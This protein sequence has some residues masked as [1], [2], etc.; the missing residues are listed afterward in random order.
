[1]K[2]KSVWEKTKVA[3]IRKR[4]ACGTYYLNKWVNGKVVGCSLETT[5]W[6]E[7]QTRFYQKLATLSLAKPDPAETGAPAEDLS[8]GDLTATYRHRVGAGDADAKTKLKREFILRTLASSWAKVPEFKS[9]GLDDLGTLKPS[10]ITFDDYLAW[11]KHFLAPDADHEDYDEDE[12]P[13]LGYSADYFNRCLQVL[14]D[15]NELAVERGCLERGRDGK[16]AIERVDRA[17][18]DQKPYVLPTAEEFAK[19]LAYNEGTYRNGKSHHCR[20]FVE[21]LSYCGLRRGEAWELRVQHI[22]LAAG[23]ITLPRD[24]VKGRKGTKKGRVVPI[25]PDARALFARLVANAGEDGRV[26][27]VDYVRHWLE[28]ATKAA[29]WKS[30]FTVHSLRHYFATRC[31]EAGVPVQTVA[32][33]LGH[34]DN[35]KLLLSTYAHVCEKH[36][37]EIASRITGWSQTP[38]AA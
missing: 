17:R 27:Q 3:G 25:L 26:F 12:K 31:L 19:I 33:W 28:S 20:D 14:T 21:A 11:R 10:K 15:L 2:N 5:N 7:A 8:F 6:T 32:A 35:G 4:S 1:M 34:R 23:T 29:G 13:G 36:S 24:I 18:H 22:D 16:L 9:A 30:K 37:Q 38:A